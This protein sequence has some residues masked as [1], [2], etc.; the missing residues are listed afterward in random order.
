MGRWPEA[1]TEHAMGYY[2]AEDLPFQY[3]L[4]EAFTL[5]DAYHCS[6][7]SGTN[8]NRLFLWSG[9]NDPTGRFGGPAL[10]NSHDN[11]ASL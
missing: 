10:S 9:T 11:L 8:S 2:R 3:A 4:A 6:I 1:K 7:Q 5:C